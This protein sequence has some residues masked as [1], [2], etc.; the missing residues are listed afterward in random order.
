MGK[1]IAT[2]TA[3]CYNKKTAVAQ[4]FMERKHCMNQK[5]KNYLIGM[6]CAIAAMFVWIFVAVALT[7]GRETYEFTDSDRIIMTVFIVIEI[8]TA[9]IT[10]LMA[11][12]FGKEQGNQFL[13]TA[14]AARTKGSIKKHNRGSALLIL[15]YAVSFGTL[16]GGIVLGKNFPETLRDMRDWVLGISCSAAASM[17]L[18][19]ILL[20]KWYV[21]K[22]EKQKVGDVQRFIHAHRENAEK[23][24]AQKLSF[25]KKWRRFTEIYAVLL[26]VLGLHVVLFAGLTYSAGNAVFFCF[27]A[28]V[29]IM[30][31]C[32]RIRFPED[33]EVFND[34]KSY[35]REDEYPHL[36]A[37][38]KRAANT[39]GCTGKIRI[40][41]LPD[42][43][44]GIAKVG[45]IY[46]VGLGVI[47]LCT[48]S[49]EEVYSVLLHEFAHMTGQNNK[50]QKERNYYN[51]LYKGKLPHFLSGI[52]NLF[53]AFFDA[54]YTL[55]FGLYEYA[56]SIQIESAADQ[57]MLLC[58][59]PSVAASALIKIRYYELFSWEKGT[60]DESCMYESEQPNPQLLTKELQ[61][62]LAAMETHSEKW[63]Q[64][65][66]VEI[67]SRSATHPTLRSRLEALGMR[68]PQ[69]MTAT[70]TVEHIKECQQ[71]LAYL[72]GLLC[73]DLTE[74]YEE[75][76]KAYYLEPKARVEAWE[77]A[78]KPLVAQEY[79]DVIWALRQVGKNTEALELCER[80]IAELPPA[81]SSNG[82]FIRGCYRLHSYDEAGITDIYTALE[83]NSN[84][85]QEGIEMIGTFCCLTGN[86]EE[87]DIYRQKAVALV[88]KFKDEY[89]EVCV[90]NKK[91]RLSEENLPEGMLE[92]I[93]DYIH[94]VD[95]GQIDGIY[96]VRKTITK[97]FF[98]SVFVIS[99]ESDTE[100]D[101]RNEI[102]HKIFR[103]LDTS[104]DWQFSLF[105]YRDVMRV[106]VYKVKNSCVYI[107]KD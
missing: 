34:N 36:Y 62:F 15:A 69:H 40:A 61:R 38:A 88:Q 16:I 43:N 21:G 68:H 4:G 19:N 91:D 50:V 8:L 103:Y 102:L 7:G 79:G 96:L 80:S 53:F 65:I 54:V 48:L 3:S 14:N 27:V 82:Y 5:A 97:D 31:A 49:E 57:A 11:V 12:L 75:R 92:Q 45:Q 46:S 17:L 74:E 47:L 28:A 60:Q 99:F 10:F 67:Q 87:L 93:L 18:L 32:S 105:D 107:K 90:L 72:D 6:L 58:G 83:N 1:K 20:K 26:G 24:A 100:D 95:G 51:W 9:I 63:R 77:E 76:R 86:Q 39:I 85:L 94:S 64:L 23:T 41:L 66:D 44:A 13:Q 33:E 106:P 70:D 29:L 2:R 78:G 104:S 101:V 42:C 98:T 55:Q 59:K 37:Q 30:C 22:L 52:T 25:I 84:Y 71:A 89:S 56:S 81:A 35:I 73:E